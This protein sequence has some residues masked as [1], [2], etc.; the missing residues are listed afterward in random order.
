M[1]PASAFGPGDFMMI[2]AEL[3]RIVGGPGEAL[4]AALLYW[5]ARE[6]S[7]YAYERD[8]EWWWNASQGDIVDAT[9]L[10]LDQV[11][12]AGR[13]LTEQGM[14]DTARHQ[15]KGI[16]DRSYSYRV[17]SDTPMRAGTRI[18]AGQSPHVEEGQSPL[19][20]SIKT[21]KTT[22]QRAS[23]YP[24]GLAWN[25]AHALKAVAKGVD[26][27]VE[28]QK[29]TDYHLAKGSKFVDWDRAFHTWLN[30]AR[31][32]PGFGQH[33]VGGGSRTPPPRRSRDDEIKD[34]L[35]GSLGLDNMKEIGQ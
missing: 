32:E 2:R 8:G 19:L 16:Q 9:G 20:P 11:R 30:N 28:F 12:R 35:G 24:P 5:R 3:V 14:I 13:V 33:A 34:F 10:T 15:L 1:I 7:P 17:V 27:E 23:Q 6:G 29:F 26:V 31:P 4:V 25:N 21:V 22:T 18:E